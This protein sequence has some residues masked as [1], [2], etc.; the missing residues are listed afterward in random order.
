[1]RINTWKRKITFKKVGKWTPLAMRIKIAMSPNNAG[2]TSNNHTMGS[3]EPNTVS[4]HNRRTHKYNRKS[5]SL[6]NLHSTKKVDLKYM[7]EGKGFPLP[8]PD[9]TICSRF[10]ISMLFFFNADK[11]ASNLSGRITTFASSPSEKAYMY[12][13]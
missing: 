9:Y 10:H 13:M 6:N 5:L 7:T 12:S 4:T 3:Y 2:A 8:F 1:M 11:Q